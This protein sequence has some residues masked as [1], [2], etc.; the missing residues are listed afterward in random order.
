MKELKF[1][2]WYFFVEWKVR[3]CPYSKSITRA[4]RKALIKQMFNL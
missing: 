4:N 2:L 1:K 3:K